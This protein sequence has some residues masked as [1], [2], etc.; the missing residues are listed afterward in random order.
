MHYTTDRYQP[1]AS[2]SFLFAFCEWIGLLKRKGLPRYILYRRANA[3]HV[4][5]AVGDKISDMEVKA[6]Y[7]DIVEDVQR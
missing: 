5:V 1:V 2:I 6:A 3:F 4:D 7:E